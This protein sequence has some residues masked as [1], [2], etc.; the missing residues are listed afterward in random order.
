[1]DVTSAGHRNTFRSCHF[2]SPLITAQAQDN[3]YIGVVRDSASD[4]FY[5]DCTFGVQTIFG[6]QDVPLVWLGAGKGIT[7]FRD[8]KFLLQNSNTSPYFIYFS[9]SADMGVTFFEN[10]KFYADLGA[11]GGTSA[12]AFKWA[13]TT[14]K[15][16]AILD[17][18]CSFINVTRVCAAAQDALV[19][20]ETP[21]V[22]TDDNVGMLGVAPDLT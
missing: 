15:A 6:N 21:Y 3:G 10:C 9:N 5:D 18:R 22:S 16:Y 17:S 8:C 13:G 2:A 14:W 7:V 1:M 12:I 20:F 4:T 19:R 11:P